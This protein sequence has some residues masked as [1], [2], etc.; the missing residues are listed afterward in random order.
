MNECI[1]GTSYYRCSNY[2]VRN[3]LQ[4]VEDAVDERECP[5]F[6]KANPVVGA[7]PDACSTHRLDSVFLG[8]PLVCAMPPQRH[9]IPASSLN[10]PTL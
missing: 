4:S 7:S 1:G 8:V 6:L 3:K 10:G 5:V 9:V 2:P